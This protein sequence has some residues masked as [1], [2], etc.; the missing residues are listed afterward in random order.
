[1]RGEEAKGSRVWKKRKRGRGRREGEGEEEGMR[2][3][4]IGMRGEE[5]KGSR[6]WKKRKRGRGRREGEGEE[7]G[8]LREEEKVGV[9]GRRE[10]K[11]RRGCSPALKPCT[12]KRRQRETKLY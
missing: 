7:K 6:L 12:N 10:S 9:G 4:E 2:K 5:E 11:S 8:I 3:E 1:M